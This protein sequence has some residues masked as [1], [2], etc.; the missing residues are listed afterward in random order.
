ME[1]L[2]EYTLRHW[3]LMLAFAIVLICIFIYE[4]IIA[5]KQAKSLSVEQ[6]IDAINHQSAVVIDIRSP[7]LYRQGHILNAIRASEA[8]F[9]LP[10]LQ[11]YKD[12]PI[13]LVCMR[14][15]E[16]N[17]LA[18]RLHTQGFSNVMTLT[19]GISAWQAAQLPLVKK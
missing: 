6:A 11:R 3:P 9:K 18:T 15:I 2:S 13:I 17:L 10:K 16:S 14:G 4:Y 19:G 1:H 8:D 7:D 5:Q 12:K